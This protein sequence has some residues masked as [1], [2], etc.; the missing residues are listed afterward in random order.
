MNTPKN[1]TV[2]VTMR[3]ENG[4]K[5]KGIHY[6]NVNLN[7]SY[8]P[9][10]SEPRSNV[11][12]IDGNFI[13]AFYQGHK[14]KATKPVNFSAEKLN[15]TEVKR[16]F[17][18]NKTVYFRLDLATAVRF[19]IMAWNTKRHKLMV[20]ANVEVNDLGVKVNKKRIKLGNKATRNGLCS[21]QVGILVNLLIWVV[22]NFW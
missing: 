12:L 22:L 3:L 18:T 14:K 20:G 6:D 13:P 17:S 15:W 2:Y 21:L 7:L 8:I 16:V 1:T 9:N 11:S 19:K 5:D 4:N 10:I